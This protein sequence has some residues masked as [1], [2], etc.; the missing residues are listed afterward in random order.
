[1]KVTTEQKKPVP[2]EKIFLGELFECSLVGRKDGFLD[3]GVPVN[4]PLLRIQV[5]NGDGMYAVDLSS[6]FTYKIPKDKEVMPLD[7]E[8]IVRK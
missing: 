2:M 5:L 7:G 8:L 4:R 6:G 1:M 3:E